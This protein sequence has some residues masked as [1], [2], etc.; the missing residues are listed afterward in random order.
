[1]KIRIFIALA[2][3]FSALGF[4]VSSNFQ[5]ANGAHRVNF[6][7]RCAIQPFQTAYSGSKAVFIGEVV[8]DEKN[9]DVRTFEFKVEKYWKG[10]VKKKTKVLVYEN[11]RFQAWFRKG[12]KYLIYANADDKGRLSVSRCSRSRDLEFAEEDLQKLGKGKIPR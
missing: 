4:G 10:A 3:V 11:A 1:M 2:A 6:G 5:T 8:S 9:G 12:G 7:A